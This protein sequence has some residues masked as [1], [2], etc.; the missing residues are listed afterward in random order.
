MAQAPVQK[1]TAAHR[2]RLIL[3]GMVLGGITGIICHALGPDIAKSSTFFANIIVTI[4]LRLIKMIIAPLVFATLAAGIG[5][6]GD[7]KDVGR[8]GIRVMIWFAA[9]SLVSLTIGLIAANILQPGLG[10]RSSSL[11]QT[12]DSTLS[13]HG[14]FNITQFFIHIVPTSVMDA[15]ARNDILELVVFAIMFGIGITALPKETA[16]RIHEAVDGLAHIMLRMTDM[17]MLTAPIAVFAA[18]MEATARSGA[19]ILEH[20]GVFLL[21]FYGVV[22][23]LWI[24]LIGAGYMMLGKR[25]FSLIKQITEPLLLGYATASSESVFPLLMEKLEEWGVP[26]KISGFVIPLGYSFNLDGSMVFESF[27][28]LF[29]AQAYGIEM[30][31]QQQITMLLVMFI[32]SKGVAGV[33]RASLVMIAAVI[34]NFGLPEAGLMLIIGIDHFLDMARTATNVIGNAIAAAISVRWAH[35]LQPENALESPALPSLQK[36]L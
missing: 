1:S 31:L 2:T 11:P 34:P 25:V 30:S 10:F 35:S 17:V 12:L 28:A 27:A 19:G 8:I 13:S 29:I 20:F 14:K 36:E 7:T 3:L 24:V 33:P 4:F 21:E 22:L 23:V 5:G 15:M 26:P 32:S 18:I 6:L 16:Q 9:A